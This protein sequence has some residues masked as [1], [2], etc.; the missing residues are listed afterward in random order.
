MY[1]VILAISY[2]E[3]SSGLKTFARQACSVIRVLP[4]TFTCCQQEINF[5]A[6]SIHRKSW[7]RESGILISLKVVTC[8]YLLIRNLLFLLKD[9][10]SVK[11]YVKMKS[12]NTTEWSAGAKSDDTTFCSCYKKEF[13][14][15]V[16]RTI[17]RCLIHPT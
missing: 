6:S 1:Y 5:A 2:N 17:R 4:S 14:S 3:C 7:F 13:S 15:R 11:F 16:S 12:N 9:D 10:D 8:D